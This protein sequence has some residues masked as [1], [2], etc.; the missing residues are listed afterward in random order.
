MNKKG[1]VLCNISCTTLNC[2]LQRHPPMLHLNSDGSL[3]NE[4]LTIGKIKTLEFFDGFKDSAISSKHQLK[5]IFEK[6]VSSYVEN[7]AISTTK[8]FEDFALACPEFENVVICAYKSI[9]LAFNFII[10]LKSQSVR[11]DKIDL[12]IKYFSFT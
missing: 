8:D 10:Y 7:N 9:E 12:F 1:A 3:I 6:S 5:L 11:Y 4:P 2:S